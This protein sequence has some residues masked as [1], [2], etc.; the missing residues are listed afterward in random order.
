MENEEDLRQRITSSL[1]E[2]LN[3]TPDHLEIQI[4]GSCTDGEAKV[5][6]L[7]VS[8]SFNSLKRLDRHKLVNAAMKG[9][10]DDGGEIHALT[11]KLQT[12]EQ[13]NK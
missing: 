8:S 5:T 9:Y 1:T 2:A 13:Y 7:V 12:P 11:L 3:G 4:E 10:L 6:M